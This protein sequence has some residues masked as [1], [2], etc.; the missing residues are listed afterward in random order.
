MSYN[1]IIL[2]IILNLNNGQRW[3]KENRDL[4]NEEKIYKKRN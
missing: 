4:W 3:L 1:I 2:S